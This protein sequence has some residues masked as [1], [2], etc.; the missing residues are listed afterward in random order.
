[1]TYNLSMVN[2]S[3][4]VPLIQT[5]NTELMFGWFGNLFLLTFFVILFLAFSRSSGNPSGSF[6]W[7]ATIC[8][9]IALPLRALSIVNDMAVFITWIILAISI[10]LLFIKD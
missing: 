10:F 2:G 1:M 7:A 8:A 4:L 5:V 6:S 9:L 3:G